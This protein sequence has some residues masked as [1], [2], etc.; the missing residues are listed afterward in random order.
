MNK[1]LTG[2]V[3]SITGL[4]LLFA[5]WRG[6]DLP[7]PVAAAIVALAAIVTSALFPRWAEARGLVVDA[8]PAALT[9][10]VVTVAVWAGPLVGWDLTQTEAT[11][12]V[13]S[14]ILVVSLLTPRA[15]QTVPAVYGEGAD[16]DHE[17]VTLDPDRDRVGT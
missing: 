17:S 16:S 15:E 12:I 3:A 1:H 11:S 2:A 13:T 14:L 7:E 9:G 6:L 8:H 4:V 5:E 10:L